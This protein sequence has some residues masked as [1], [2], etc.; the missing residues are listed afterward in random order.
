MRLLLLVTS[1]LAMCALALAQGPLPPPLAS[2]LAR[3]Q[4]E[5]A[6]LD[7]PRP[8]RGLTPGTSDTTSVLL[9]T[10]V[11]FFGGMALTA[12]TA[13]LMQL[14]LL[15]AQ[16]LIGGYSPVDATGK[17]D[18]TSLS[19]VQHIVLLSLAGITVAMTVFVAVY[20]TQA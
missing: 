19:R 10:L 17:P 20:F 7:A 15:R 1:V 8:S 3:I 2:E 14:R 13:A 12:T 4:L 11:V 6:A 9:L 16:R 5:M 18:F